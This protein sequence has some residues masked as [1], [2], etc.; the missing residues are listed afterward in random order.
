MIEQNKSLTCSLGKYNFPWKK[1][2]Q[3]WAICHQYVMVHTCDCSHHVIKCIKWIRALAAASTCFTSRSLSKVK[4]SHLGTLLCIINQDQCGNFWSVLCLHWKSLPENLLLCALLPPNPPTHTKYLFCNTSINVIQSNSPFFDK[5]RVYFTFSV[6]DKWSPKLAFLEIVSHSFRFPHMCS[7][8]RLVVSI[9]PVFSVMLWCGYYCIIQNDNVMGMTMHGWWH[10]E[11][12]EIDNDDGYSITA[13]AI[14]DDDG[15][16]VA[17]VPLSSIILE[18]LAGALGPYGR[19]AGFAT[20]YCPTTLTTITIQALTFQQLQS[21]IAGDLNLSI[22]YYCSMKAH[23]EMNE[24]VRHWETGEYNQINGSN[25]LHMTMK[26]TET[27]KTRFD[28]HQKIV[29]WPKTCL[30]LQQVCS[31]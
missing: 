27:L 4:P 16:G 8:E 2:E 15:D 7:P 19:R 5:E 13:L 26:V 22:I 3:K 6:D 14:K 9:V 25:G 31:P 18:P 17:P 10:Q 28:N 29:F 12:K 21:Y 11:D 30:E 20:R 23:L 24:T 1:C